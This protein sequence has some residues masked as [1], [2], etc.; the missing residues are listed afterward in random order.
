MNG[1]TSGYTEIDAPAAG[2]NNTLVLP[3][4]NGTADQALVTN[5]SGTLSFADRGRMVLET[6]QAST[7]GTSIDFT[8]IP[9]WV[10]RVTVMFEG[11]STNGSSLPRLQLG[12]SGGIET[13]GYSGQSAQIYGGASGSAFASSAGFDIFSDGAS[14][15]IAGHAVFTLISGST[16]VFSFTGATSAGVALVL[17][18]GGVKTLS[19]TLDRIRITT[20][21]GTDTFDAGSINILYEG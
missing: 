8:S 16:W 3:T 15:G 13:T 4:G 19:A 10:K 1:S 6:A 21:N 12:D 11:V 18:S 9:S 2:G 20:V 7:S 17:V 14:N 5:G